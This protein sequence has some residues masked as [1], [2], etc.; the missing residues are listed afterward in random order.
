MPFGLNDAVTI[1]TQ[2]DVSSGYATLDWSD[3]VGIFLDQDPSAYLN[4][5]VVGAQYQAEFLWV[6]V[7]DIP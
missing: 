7:H 4:N 5:L 1:L 3:T 6:L 2:A